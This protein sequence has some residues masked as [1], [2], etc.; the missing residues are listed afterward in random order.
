MS[1]MLCKRL[2]YREEGKKG[3]D[4]GIPAVKGFSLLI[5]PSHHIMGLTCILYRS[6][7]GAAAGLLS[8]YKGE[9]EDEGK[10]VEEVRR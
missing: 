10:V 9:G 5:S 3:K 7:N 6:T 8:C 4:G 1:P 2:S